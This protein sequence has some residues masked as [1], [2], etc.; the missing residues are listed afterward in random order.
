MNAAAHEFLESV[1]QLAPRVAAFDCDGTLWAGDAGERFFD[2]E[3]RAGDVV[4]D[5]SVAAL[6]ERYSTYKQ[7][8]VDETTM[9]GIVGLYCKSPELEP[10][11]DGSGNRVRLWAAARPALG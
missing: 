4:P 10:R 11:L 3:L 6:R 2:W 9:C 5:V 7:G 1:L 8:E